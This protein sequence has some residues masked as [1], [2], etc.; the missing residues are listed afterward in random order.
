MKKTI[1]LSC[2]STILL[3]GCIGGGSDKQEWT[4]FIYP[5]KTNTKRSKVF[6]KYQTL[7]QCQASSKD[8]LKKLDLETRGFYE[9]GLNC[10]YHEGMKVEIC[11]KMS[12]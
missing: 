3:T 10:E 1:L 9:C 6:G 11:E 7:E 4:S 12:K 8:E 2:L 5:D